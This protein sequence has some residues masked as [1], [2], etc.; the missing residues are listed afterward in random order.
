MRENTEKTSLKT[1]CNIR[2]ATFARIYNMRCLY[3]F[4]RRLTTETQLS[5]VTA[6]LLAVKEG[7]QYFI[8]WS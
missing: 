8:R 5:S 3:V 2:Q 6:G 4:G 1:C 7:G